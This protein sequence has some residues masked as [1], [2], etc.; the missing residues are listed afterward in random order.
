MGANQP[1]AASDELAYTDIP[2]VRPQQTN[3]KTHNTTDFAF[4]SCTS[5][6][7]RRIRRTQAHDERALPRGLE[8]TA[9][10]LAR[11]D[12]GP[13]LAARAR[14]RDVLHARACREVPDQPGG[15]EEDTKEQVGAEEGGED[16]VGGEGAEAEAGVYREA[17]REGEGGDD[18]EI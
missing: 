1:L 13:A 16:E 8:P 4:F 12:G 10:D 2:L 7:A 5:A 18:G 15:G 17:G 6:N 9:E 3:F 14:P 11:R